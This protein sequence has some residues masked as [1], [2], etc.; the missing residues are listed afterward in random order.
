MAL[1]YAAMNVRAQ[2]G[3]T[4]DITHV[5]QPVYK[6]MQTDPLRPFP[7]EPAQKKSKRT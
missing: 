2:I 6:M 7:R 1:R 3:H 4:T 5:N